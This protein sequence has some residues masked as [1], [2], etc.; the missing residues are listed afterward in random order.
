VRENLEFYAG[1]Y[2]VNGQRR[3]ARVEELVALA[4]LEGR[5]GE[6]AANL[7]GGWK[8]RLALAAP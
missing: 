1:V 8:Q 3:R 2:Q 7:S 6:L 4:G 5:E